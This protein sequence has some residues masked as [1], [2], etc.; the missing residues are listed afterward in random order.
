MAPWSAA[1]TK[2][3]TCNQLSKRKLPLAGPHAIGRQLAELRV[4]QMVHL[5]GVLVDGVRDDRRWIRTSLTRSDTGA[6]ACEVMLV[7]HVESP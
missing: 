5:T 3:A 6:G 4:G 7:E 2:S 1:V